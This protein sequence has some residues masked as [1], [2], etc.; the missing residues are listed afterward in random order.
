MYRIVYHKRRKSNPYTVQKQFMGLFWFTEKCTRL[1]ST[2]E[3][4]FSITSRIS[5]KTH[6][7]AKKYIIK[8]QTERKKVIVEMCP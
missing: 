4:T 7:E 6:Y 2:K 3:N 8:Q 5:F 1:I